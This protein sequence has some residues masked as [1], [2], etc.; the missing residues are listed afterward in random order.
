M[1]YK[2]K[3]GSQNGTSKWWPLYAGG[4]YSEVVEMA[5]TPYIR[6]YLQRPKTQIC[7]EA[8]NIKFSLSLLMSAIISP[9]V[10]N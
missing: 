7:E 10:P 8:F 5:T 9:S 1:L 2:V 3:M 4:R 6:M